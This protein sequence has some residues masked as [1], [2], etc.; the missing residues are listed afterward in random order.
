MKWVY[1][2]VSLLLML[3]ALGAVMLAISLAC[4]AYTIHA[5]GSFA[6][7]ACAM[8]VSLVGAVGIRAADELI[9]VARNL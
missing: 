1:F 2:T 6:L 4:W 3:A 8:L 9:H 7:L 5:I